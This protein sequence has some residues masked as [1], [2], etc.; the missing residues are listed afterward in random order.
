MTADIAAQPGR[1][2]PKPLWQ[3]S[4]FSMDG[5]PLAGFVKFVQ[6]RHGLDFGVPGEECLRALHQWSVENRAAFW[7][8]LWDFA[9]VD[10]EKGDVVINK[11]D[12]V[13]W[14]RFFPNGN[15]SYAENMLKYWLAH[16]DEMAVIYRHQGGEDRIWSGR[17]L[18]EQVSLW[19]QAL[20]GVGIGE[21][22]AV[23]V[24][25]TNVPETVAILLAASNIGAPLVTAGMEMGGDD[26]TERFGRAHP[27]ILISADS[28]VY[29]EKVIGRLDVLAR[30]Q[31]EISSIKQ[32]VLI[33]SNSGTQAMDGLKNVQSAEAFLGAYNPQ[34]LKFTR[35]DFN[36]PLYIL[37]SSGTTGA[38]KGFIHSTGGVLLKHLSEYQLHADVRPG[39]KMFY[40]ATPSW[41]M[42]NWLVSALASGACVVM[43][44]GAPNV[45]DAK[46]QL[47]FTA[48]YNVEHHGTAA[49]VIAGL[50]MH[51]GKG[52]TDVSDLD[53][54]AMRQILYTGAVLAPQGFEFIDRH[55]KKGV[56]VSGV[57]GGTDFVG[58]SISGNP[59]MP[60]YAGQVAH[61]Q[62]GV[63]L[64][65]WDDAGKRL[66]SGQAGELVIAQPFPSMPLRF[67][68]DP[69]GALYRE[70]YFD[71]FAGT[72][73]RVWRHGDTIQKTDQGQILI[74]GRSDA[75]L[76]Q[77]GV[78]IGPIKIYRQLE[79]DRI[80]AFASQINAYTAI[81][82][83][84]PDNDLPITVLFL[85]LEDGEQT[86]PEDMARAIRSA[87]KDNVGAN[88]IPTEI[89]AVPG[90]LRTK[91]GKLAE[92]VTG[93]VIN[94]KVIKNAS[95][96]G[97]D[98]VEF[99]AGQGR[100][101]AEKY[102]G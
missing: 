16:S 76:N 38:P 83:K 5:S 20:R 54:S 82:F 41:M 65:I 14:E 91:N 8:A 92:V 33:P 47:R 61:P 26:M 17:E 95:L 88:S 18:C 99:Y 56:Q 63:D 62:L 50:W 39:E 89:I 69:D 2:E 100:K 42:W 32:T 68:D 78:R 43:H 6:D 25:L 70:A 80:G 4:A 101:L 23:G 64:Q 75:T 58:V 28:Y 87:V 10:G 86:V 79:A 37:F 22:D 49:P 94:G 9:G 60:V 29:G 40:H 45:P 55:V 34:P 31:G 59:F 81:D 46:A 36:H 74:I 96:Y 44:D 13:P 52:I 48:K 98:L 102:K 67:I 85:A 97:E 12:I 93:K 66:E 73:K 35:R 53:L 84:R 30:A 11:T 90:V 19:E 72:G 7:D 3:P 57:C 27:K 21:G 77:N 24:Y 15:I 51:E 71:H 1:S